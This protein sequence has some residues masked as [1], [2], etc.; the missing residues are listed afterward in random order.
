MKRFAMKIGCQV[1]VVSAAVGLALGIGGL[2]VVAADEP[3]IPVWDNAIGVPGLIAGEV[4]ALV[5]YNDDL[6]AGGTFSTAGGDVVNRIAR[7]DGTSW[8]SLAGGMNTG[9]LCYSPS[10]GRARG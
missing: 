8:H 4:N 5:V 9:V 6:I 7:W 2:N 1:H 10:S 3:C